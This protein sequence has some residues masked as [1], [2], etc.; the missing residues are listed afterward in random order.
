L[1]PRQ[2][3]NYDLDPLRIAIIDSGVDVDYSSDP[4]EALWRLSP[5]QKRTPAE[6]VLP[7]RFGFDFIE[8]DYT[9]NDP[10][11]HGNAV[12]WSIL[13]NY[14]GDRPLDLIHL[15]TFGREGA[16]SYFGTLVSLYE[17]NRVGSDLINMSWGIY[18]PKAPEALTC[19]VERALADDILLVTSAGNDNE[20]LNATPQWP[21]A[22][23]EAYPDRIFSVASYWYGLEAFDANSDPDAARKKDYSNFGPPRVNVAGYFTNPI[24]TAVGADPYFPIGTSI[25]APLIIAELANRINSDPGD[26]TGALMK[27]LNSAPNLSGVVV[28]ERYLPLPPRNPQP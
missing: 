12:T 24:P 7:N 11:P 6:Y 19:A 17:A 28:K 15:K 1:Q 18:T 9:P 4:A 14:R 22:Y 8:N 16:A 26:P 27:T 5:N 3:F 25:S 13:N 23:A 10:L 21:A 2:N 20:D